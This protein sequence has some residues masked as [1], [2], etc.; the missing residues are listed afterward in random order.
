MV[1]NITGTSAT[2]PTLG[3]TL[4]YYGGATVESGVVG[5]PA[6]VGGNVLAARGKDWETDIFQGL[7]VIIA[8]GAGRGQARRILGNSN[9]M[10]VIRGTWTQ[11]LDTSSAF[12]IVLGRKV[13]EPGTVSPTT[14]NNYADALNWFCAGYGNK[15][16][17]LKNTHG[18]NSLYYRVLVRAHP[19]GQ[20]AEEVAQ[21][22]LAAGNLARI[23][24]NNAYARVVLQV[25][26]A[27]PGSQATYQ[28]DWIGLPLGVS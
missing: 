4:A 10:L 8:D 18:S 11:A 2:E 5:A 20:D 14:T 16:I 15:T 22:V 12:R 21:T 9:K 27:V 6:P 17:V 23:A 13:G 25:R 24:L 7:T 26:A 1:D 19:D 28:V 3:A